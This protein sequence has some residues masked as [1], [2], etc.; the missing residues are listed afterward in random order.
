M[1]C[2]QPSATISAFN[3]LRL[4]LRGILATLFHAHTPRTEDRRQAGLP[5][6]STMRQAGTK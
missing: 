6:R 4:L 1:L 2:S 3:W 5:N